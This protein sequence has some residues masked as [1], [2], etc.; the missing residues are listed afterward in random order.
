MPFSTNAHWQVKTWNTGTTQGGS[1]GCGIFDANNRLVGSLSGG[2]ASCNNPRNDYFMRLNRAWKAG[3]APNEQLACWLNPNNQSISGIGGMNYYQSRMERYS[4]INAGS[5]P[6]AIRHKG[7][8]TGFVA[9]HNSWHHT[10][11]AQ[12]FDNIRKAKIKGVYL[13]SGKSVNY[14][15]QTFSIHLWRD[16][17]GLPGQTIASI[18]NIA[19]SSLTNNAETLY[20]FANAIEVKEPIHVGIEISYQQTAIDSV[21]ILVNKGTIGLDKNRFSIFEGDQWKP[22]TDLSVS[23]QPSSLWVDILASELSV[24]E[25]PTPSTKNDLLLYPQKVT[26]G[27]TAVIDNDTIMSLMVYNMNGSVVISQKINAQSAFISCSHLP[28][29]IYLVKTKLGKRTV[30][31]KI[32]KLPN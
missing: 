22:F 16:D 20:E 15:D 21:A 19:V 25:V 27:F 12:Y 7:F 13:V 23:N 30:E 4:F 10:A 18:E 5:T 14:S 29:G 24:G 8:G 6:S 28:S 9:G 17:N 31:T 3:S 2:E 26:N 1:S 11:F 32:L